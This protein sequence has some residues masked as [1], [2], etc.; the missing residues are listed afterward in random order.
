LA[1][2][3]GSPFFYVLT[4]KLAK[5]GQWLTATFPRKVGG[6]SAKNLNL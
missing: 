1:E 2:S 6:I 5:G 3:H 4:F